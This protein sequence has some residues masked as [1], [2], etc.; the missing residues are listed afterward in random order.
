M[1]EP[2]LH[3]MFSH[4]SDLPYSLRVLYT[5]ALLVIG[6]GYLFALIYIFAS[7][8]PKDGDPTSLTYE[9]IV[10]GYSGSGEDSRLEAALRGPMRSMLPADDT[11]IIISW[12]RDGAERPTYESRVRPIIEKRCLACHDGSNPHLVNLTG[13]DNTKKMTEKDTGPAVTTL[14]RVSH[15]HLFGLSFIFFIVG[16]IFSHAYVRPVWLKC[17]VIATPFVCIVLDVIS[18]YL[19]KLFHPFAWVVMLGGAAYGAAFAFMWVVSMYQLWFSGTPTLVAKRAHE[20]GV[21]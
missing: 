16:I 11:A 2:P 17:A 3:P 6:M 8:A 20:R 18:W 4:F 7:Y 1:S 9:D 21:G 14:V 13:F 5:A 19:V 15:I 10:I 12:V